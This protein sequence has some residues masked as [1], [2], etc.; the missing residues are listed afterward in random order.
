[1]GGLAGGTALGLLSCRP[2]ILGK[3]LC[4]MGMP[5]LSGCAGKLGTLITLCSRL[6]THHA[7]ELAL[8]SSARNVA[9]PSR[10]PWAHSTAQLAASCSGRFAALVDCHGRLFTFG[11]GKRVLAGAA[12]APPAIN[13]RK[14]YTVPLRHAAGHDPGPCSTSLRPFY[15]PACTSGARALLHCALLV[16]SR[17]VRRAGP[18][19]HRQA[20]RGAPGQGA[21]GACRA[22]HGLWR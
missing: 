12:A 21:G 8:G 20:R 22:C 19:R 17:Q 6:C 18:R 2:A 3:S 9:S 10:M 14:A 4:R 5:L 11:A 15:R 7:G 1:M 13:C 16:P